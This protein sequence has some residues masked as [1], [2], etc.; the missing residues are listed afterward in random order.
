[1]NKILQKFNI[2]DDTRSVSIP[3]APYFK[4]KATMSLTTIEEREYMTHISY[5]SAV[6]I[7]IYVMVCTRPN[8]SQDVSIVS[9]YMHGPCGCHLEAVKWILRYIKDTIDVGLMFKKNSTGK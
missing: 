5:A 6:G 7:L 4:L 9:R 8:L 2:N 1:L 3:L